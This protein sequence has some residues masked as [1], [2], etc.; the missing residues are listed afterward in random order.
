MTPLKAVK[1]LHERTLTYNLLLKYAKRPEKTAK[2]VWKRKQ[3]SLAFYLDEF[4]RELRGKRGCK[5]DLKILTSC[6]VKTSLVLPAEMNWRLTIGYL[7]VR[8][9]ANQTPQNNDTRDWSFYYAKPPETF[10]NARIFNFVRKKREK[11]SF[12]RNRNA[13]KLVIVFSMC[14]VNLSTLNSRAFISF[15]MFILDILKYARLGNP[16]INTFCVT[17]SS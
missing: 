16:S 13:N 9:T 2:F 12:W 15:E 5:E 3:K 11:D 4:H 10:R 14:P 8:P 17:K 1:A 6:E 7:A